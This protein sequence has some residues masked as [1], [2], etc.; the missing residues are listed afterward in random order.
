MTEPRLPADW[1]SKL[2][3]LLDPYERQARLYPG[4]LCLLP[5]LVMATALYGH[6]LLDL[7]GLVALVGAAGVAY[8]LGDIARSQ[9]KAKE[10]ALWT[11][12]GGVPSVQVLRHRDETL[13]AVSKRRYHAL[14]AKKIKTPFPTM[15]AELADPRGADDLYAAGGNWLREATRDKKK[16]GLLFK[17]NV[18]YGFRRNGYGLRW[19][20]LSICLAV[21]VWI[22]LRSGMK[23]WAQRLDV[24]ATP[25]ALLT[26][27]E[28]VTL[29]SVVGMALV[30]AFFFSEE[31]VRQAAFSYASRLALACELVAG[32]STAEAKTAKQ[33][34]AEESKT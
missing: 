14:L 6:Q 23:A 8:L 24:A 19:I 26:T 25:E 4:L 27:G 31:G 17:D 7:K 21:A 1:L 11:K 9:G 16:F 20:G 12:W 32:I 15:E 28:A 30:W 18:T 13:D 5:A 22:A 34:P 33:P 2:G 29:A 10:K 3:A